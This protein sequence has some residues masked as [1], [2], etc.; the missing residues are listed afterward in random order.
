LSSENTVRKWGVKKPIF[1]ISDRR[2]R[3]IVRVR[4]YRADFPAENL[5]DRRYE[6]SCAM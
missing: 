4:F 6:F 5:K 2:R 3:M 1:S